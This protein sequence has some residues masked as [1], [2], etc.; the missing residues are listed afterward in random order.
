[1]GNYLDSIVSHAHDKLNDAAKVW[2]SQQGYVGCAVTFDNSSQE[3][4]YLYNPN[5][6]PLKVDDSV[7]VPARGEYKIVKVSKANLSFGQVFN[8]ATKL[9][10]QHID[11]SWHNRVMGAI[12]DMSYEHEAAKF[13]KEH[14]EAAQQYDTLLQMDGSPFKLEHKE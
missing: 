13:R 2:L 12:A 4:F 9:V 14:A 1:M 6:F 5:R 7:V 10:A 3:Y 11:T 8:K